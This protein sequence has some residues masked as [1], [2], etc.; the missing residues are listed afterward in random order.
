MRGMI[1]ARLL[2]FTPRVEPRR[3]GEDMELLIVRHGIAIEPDAAGFTESE[4]PLTKDGEERFRG[5]ARG[6]AELLPR[7]DAILT[8]PLVRARQTAEI[9][10][11]AWG[12]KKPV[13]DARLTAGATPAQMLSCLADYRESELVAFFGH[14]PG[15]SRL[16]AHLLGSEHGERFSFKKGGAAL[17]DLGDAPGDAGRLVGQ[18]VWFLPPRILRQAA[19]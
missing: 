3:K 18:L 6:L 13:V 16:L 12:K 5:S 9:A 4:R 14:E 7:P 15:C 2:I 11:Q 10:A 19:D 17:I 1:G 8:S